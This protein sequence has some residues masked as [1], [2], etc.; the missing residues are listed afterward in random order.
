MPGDR[1]LSFGN[2]GVQLIP[3]GGA[4]AFGRSL[5]IQ[6][7]GK[8]VLACIVSN[9]FNPDFALV[10]LTTDG[11]PDTT[12]G[13]NGMVITDFAQQNDFPG[14][15]A[16]D[17][18]DRIVVAG[19]TESGNGDDFAVARYLPN[20]ILDSTFHHH[21]FVNQPLGTTSS[22][23]AV[24]IQP[25][26]KIVTGGYFFNPS[27]LMNE[28]ALMRFNEDGTL[29]ETF[30]EDGIVT[31]NMII[32]NGIGKAMALQ[33]DGKIIL[34]GQ[35]FNDATFLWEIGIARYD[36]NG[37]PDSSFDEDGLAFLS[38][39]GGNFTI[40]SMDLQDDKKIVVGGFFGTAPSNNRFAV[41]RFHD[42]GKPDLD[43][44]D[45]GVVLDSYGAEDNQVTTLVTQP[46]GYILVAGTSLSGNADRFA[47]ARLTPDGDKDMTFGDEGVVIDVIGQNDGISSMALQQDGKLVVAGES[48]NGTKFSIAFA[49]Y[50]TGILSAV[51]DPVFNEASLSV[52]PNPAHEFIHVQYELKNTT[53]IQY[54]LTDIAGKKLNLTSSSLTKNSGMNDELIQLP[55]DLMTGMYWLSLQTPMSVET[56]KLMVT[57]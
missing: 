17:G 3:F 29:D 34:T 55:I 38:V 24:A 42:D 56:I 53:T 49:R 6:V 12:F 32:G 9:G 22:C 47:I 28:F 54:I 20:G 4:N 44:G 11:I 8:P 25:D 5:A 15:I 36:T 16:I 19:S 50:E 23:N 21:G 46:D 43:F 2:N 41:A 57:E 7:D 37:E 30:N 51:N 14:A 27:S 1:D 35:A 48:F 40:T 26:N 13:T 10:R 33:Q 18:L 52:Y 45:N 31:T 39:P